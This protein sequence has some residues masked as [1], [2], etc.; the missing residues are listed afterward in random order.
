MIKIATKISGKITKIPALLL[1]FAFVR[2]FSA[3][4][5][6]AET[7]AKSTP[8]PPPLEKKEANPLCFLDGK[9]CFDIQERLRWENRNNNFDFNSAVDSLT[10]DNWL[11]NRFRI[12]VAIKPVDWLKIYAQAQDSREWYS[13]RPNIPGAMGAEGDDNFD[14]RRGYLQLGPKLVNAKLGPQELAYGDERPIANNPTVVVPGLTYT[15]T[16]LSIP[17]TRT[18][19]VTLGTRLK[20]DPKK[21]HG[22][23]CEG[24]FAFQTG[25]VSDLDLTAFAAHIGGG[26]NF[27]CP[28]SPRL[29]AEYNYAS[30]DHDPTDGNIETFQNLFPSNHAYYGY[31][32]L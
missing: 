14:L 32:D 9:L 22:W 3:L 30:G 18:D 12:G 23:E 19:F 29:F 1:I 25:Q 11:L 16:S 7:D 28:W 4:A 5:G 8:P 27:K 10:D 17:S 26:Y 2:P 31:M 15:G 21:L 24:E 6:E 20:A 13:D